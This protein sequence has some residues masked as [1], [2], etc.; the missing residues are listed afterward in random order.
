MKRALITS[1]SSSSSSSS[2]S[3]FSAESGAGAAVVRYSLKGLASQQWAPADARELVENV[4]HRLRLQ[5]DA[6]SRLLA[7]LRR[8]PSSSSSQA[9]STTSPS[10]L[11]NEA[12]RNVRHLL[13]VHR[14]TLER[15]LQVSRHPRLFHR[16]SRPDQNDV[17]VLAEEVRTRHAP[18]LER[19]VDY[20]L[21]LKQQQQQQQQLVL[22]EGDDDDPTGLHAILQ[23]RWSVQLLCDQL[24]KLPKGRNAASSDCDVAAVVREAYT[25]ASALCDAHWQRSPDL[26]LVGVVV[27]EEEENGSKSGAAV[28]VTATIVRPW[29][30]HA[31]VELCKNAMHATLQQRHALDADR[32]AHRGAP[33]LPPLPPPITVRVVSADDP[34]VGRVVK[35]QVEDRGVGLGKE[36]EGGGGGGSSDLVPWAFLIGTTSSTS[37]SSASKWDRLNV[38]QSY[39]PVRSPLNSLGVGLPVSRMMLRHLGGDVALRARRADDGECGGPGCVATITLPLDTTIPE[40]KVCIVG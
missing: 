28:A 14:D 3:A 8:N 19:W 12:D 40:P 32:S 34:L 6:C 15:C 2:S 13:H 5:S 38:Q 36:E 20:F 27:E 35:I 9:S 29:L 10:L 31:L 21:F 7:D 30:H 23:R 39:A 17:A 33:Y 11:L 37:S 16:W 1:V 4:A 22:Q 18:G 26:D 24:V 25:E